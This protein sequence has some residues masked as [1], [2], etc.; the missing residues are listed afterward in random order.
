MFTELSSPGI[1]F[2]RAR[3]GRPA[4]GQSLVELLVVMAVAATVVA[5]G[6]QPLFNWVA[7]LRVEMAAAEVAGALQM[8]RLYAARSNVNVAVKFR[9]GADGAV[10]YALYR[11]GDGDGVRNRDIDRGIDPVERA[12]H[13]LARL[14]KGI[15]FGF[16]PGKPPRDP[17]GRRLTRLD[18]PIRFNRSDLA[19]FSSRGT[20]TP[21]TVYLTDGRYHL[22]AARVNNRAGRITVLRYDRVLGKWR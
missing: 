8:A 10:T 21:G 6:L 13:P 9:T 12:P 7:G 19:S 16:P 4:A 17:S 15:R 2:R 3:R 18:D 1:P 20:A 22:A 14:G 5:V 11:D